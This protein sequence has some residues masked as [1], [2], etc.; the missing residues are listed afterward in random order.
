M[1]RPEVTPA[2]QLFGPGHLAAL[3]SVAAVAV[4]AAWLVRRHPAYGPAIRF[5]F[6]GVLVVN[7]LGTLAFKL[8]EGFHPPE[9]L[10]LHLSDAVVFLVIIALLSRRQWCLEL[11]YYWGLG[12]GFFA[13]LTPDLEHPLPSWPAVQFFVSHGVVIVAVV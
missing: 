7:A 11:A 3:A 12:G 1:R 5:V 9:G 6:A 13:L 8:R 2:F 4:F 10:P